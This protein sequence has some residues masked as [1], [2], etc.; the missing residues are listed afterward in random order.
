MRRRPAAVVAALI[1]GCV[2]ECGASVT[3]DDAL[4][5]CRNLVA[6]WIGAH[7]ADVV[8]E[9]VSSENFPGNAWDFRGTYPGGTWAC[10]GPASQRE[11][12]QIIAWTSDGAAVTPK[13]K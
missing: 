3:R 5:Y 6:D 7:V 10:G 2:S 1:V 9:D 8:G 13:T 4:N 11:A 12:S